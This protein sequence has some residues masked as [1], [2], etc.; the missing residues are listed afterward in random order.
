MLPRMEY[1]GKTERIILG[2]TFAAVLILNLILTIH[3]EMWCDEAQ[4]WLLARD[5]GPVSIFSKVSY[6][7]HPFLWFY[8]LM[9]FAKAG[10]SFAFIKAISFCIVMLA[11]WILLFYSPFPFP[12]KII[13]AFSP[14]FLYFYASISRSYCLIALF[15]V[16]AALLRSRR[17]ERPLLFG[18]VCALL[19]QTHIIM[20]GMV[21]FICLAWLA[22]VLHRKDGSFRKAMAGLCLPLLSAV[23]LLWQMRGIAQADAVGG[24]A[25]ESLRQMLGTYLW[26]LYYNFFEL[27]DYRT[28]LMV[29]F[30]IAGMAFFGLALAAPARHAAGYTDNNA[31]GKG[32]AGIIVEALAV[33]IGGI[34]FQN[35]IYAFVYYAN[36][37]RLIT[38]LYMLIY[39][40]WF[41][42]DALS[43]R[44]EE[45][46]LKE[47]KKSKEPRSFTEADCAVGQDTGDVIP[48]KNRRML[49][50]AGAFCTIMFFCIVTGMN[51]QYA[52]LAIQDLKEPFTYA[53]ETADAINELP[54]NAVILE[55]RE[56][57]CNSV[58]PRLKDRTVLSPFGWRPASYAER[59]RA[60]RHTMT[61]D[62]LMEETRE[63]FPEAEGF[64]LLYAVVSDN[65]MEIEGLEEFLADQEPVYATPGNAMSGEDYRIYYISLR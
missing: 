29:M 8:I 6:E 37:Y 17:Q 12:A 18:L 5:M 36:V 11:V 19:L 15:T 64:Y 54:E 9:P 34:G 7:G 40:A 35:I 48:D 14:A 47:S 20:A 25:A 16:L 21:F 53:Q 45:T 30:M 23:F 33:I 10:V 27:M 43:C 22:D 60:Y 62:E 38:W 26:A 32:Y 1:K 41:L 3:H 28:W 55:N 61:V 46:G 24:E 49:T 44:H 65:Y 63:H 58:I 4:A 59:N 13:L 42:M 57:I 52:P 51:F 50:A 56:D 2:I 31:N 39:V